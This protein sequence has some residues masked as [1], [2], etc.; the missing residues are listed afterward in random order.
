MLAE[1]SAVEQAL[2]KDLAGDSEDV[3]QVQMEEK[4]VFRLSMQ[5]RLT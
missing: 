2:I 5:H 3:M 1:I 4:Y